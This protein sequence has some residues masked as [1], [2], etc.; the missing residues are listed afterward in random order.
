[1]A[2]LITPTTEKKIYVQGTLIELTSVYNRLEFGCRPNGITMEMTF[3]TYLDKAEFDVGNSLPTDLPTGN[4]TQDIDPLT[5]TQGLQ[6]A[7][8]LAKTWYESLGY[9]VVIDLA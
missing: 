4:L 7:H 1:M 6:A 3:Y 5:Q 2:L 9:N 8:K